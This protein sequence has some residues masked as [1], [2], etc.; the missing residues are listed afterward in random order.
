[1]GMQCMRLFGEPAMCLFLLCSIFMIAHHGHALYALLWGAGHVL[2]SI[3]QHLF[4]CTSWACN[5]CTPHKMVS[6]CIM[7]V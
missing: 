7:C 2:V 4:D 1:M 5:A 6:T 3:V